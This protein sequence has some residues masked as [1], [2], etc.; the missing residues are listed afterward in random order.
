MKKL[1]KTLK[2]R[3]VEILSLLLIIAALFVFN[4]CKK[5]PG[6]GGTSMIQGRVKV[7][8]YHHSLIN[9]EWKWVKKDEYYVAE[10]RVYIIYGDDNIYSTD[11]RTDPDG[12]YRFQWL[13]KGT[14]T[15]FAYSQDTTGNY[16]SGI[17]PVEI[18]LEITKN[19]QT[20][21][22]PDIVII[23]EDATGFSTISGR[24]KAKVYDY[25]PID[26]SWVFVKEYYVAKER[27]Y[28]IYGND[29]IYTDD[30]RTDPNGYYQFQGLRKN[31][32]TLFAYSID[33]T[34]SNLFNIVELPVKIG[35]EITIDYQELT[36]PDIV[37]IECGNC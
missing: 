23:K 33:T 30:F 16:V 13:R 5:E 11:F 18:K 14:Y 3:Y 17:Y 1:K 4:S 35:V 7:L 21:N 36:A 15:L 22:A 9:G 37:I 27:V 6:E 25:N 12:Y 34:K 24:V 28:L 26:G 29:D 31:T 10:E 20:V 2:F 8:D 32:Y 19:K